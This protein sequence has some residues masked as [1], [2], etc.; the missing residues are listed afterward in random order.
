MFAGAVIGIGVAAGLRFKDLKRQ[1]LLQSN[2]LSN[3]AATRATAADLWAQ[4]V[5]RV[6]EDRS[7]DPDGVGGAV[8]V[9]SELRHYSDRHWFLATQVAEVR[10]F[11]VQSCQ[12]F[13]DLASM[14][15]RGEVVSLPA[16]TDSICRPTEGSAKCVQCFC[17]MHVATA[18]RP[19]LVQRFALVILNVHHSINHILPSP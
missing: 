4:A 8:E 17:H 16:V 7:A 1:A 13:V 14:I 19:R 6:K 3:L 12:N 10:K 11:N 5:A 2:N 9:P 15:E 18:H